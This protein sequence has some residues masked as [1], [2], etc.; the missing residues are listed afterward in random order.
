MACRCRSFPIPVELRKRRTLAIDADAFVLVAV[1]RLTVEKGYGDLAEALRRLDRRG[2]ALHLIVV[3]GGSGEAEIHRL[4]EGLDDVGVHF[5]G[6]QSDVGP[7]LAASDVF[8]FPTWQ[9]NLSNALLEAMA[10]GLPVVATDV[11]GNREVVT[12]GGGVLVPPHDPAA[13]ADAIL[14]VMEDT[15]RGA[16]G[17][18]ARATVETWYSIDR[19]A[20]AWEDRYRQILGR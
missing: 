2:P 19:M 17:K 10:H 5:V 3:G 8:V 14:G 20:A 16:M 9:E 11:G 6:Q 7:F 18:A 12:K 15:D 13:L 1:S 4:F